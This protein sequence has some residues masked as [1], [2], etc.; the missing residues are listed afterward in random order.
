M[1]GGG[2]RRGLPRRPGGPALRPDPARRLAARD[3]RARDAGPRPRPSIPSVPV[4]VISGHGNIESAVQAVRMGAFDFVEKP[5]SLEKT[6]LVVRTRCASGGSRRRTAPSRRRSSSAARWS[7]RAPPCRALRE[8]VALAAPTNGRVLIFGE[9]GTGKEL[10]ARTIHAPEPARRRALRRGELRGDPRGAD[11]ER[12]LRPRARRLHRRA[13][14]RAGK[15]EL[16][17]GGTLFLDEIGDMSLKTQAKVL[18]VAPGAD[19]GAGRRHGLGR[20]STCG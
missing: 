12:A 9:N 15:F 7:A 16:A 2:E 1:R 4:V 20:R 11:R 18:R 3:G 10:V 8:Q 19:D 6:V 5:L 14:R 17:D 13:R